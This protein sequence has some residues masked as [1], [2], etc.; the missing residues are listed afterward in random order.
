MNVFKEKKKKADNYLSKQYEN[1]LFAYEQ[2]NNIDDFEKAINFLIT[3]LEKKYS[4][5]KIS[6][7]ATY[8]ELLN[9]SVVYR[10]ITPS[11]Y[12]TAFYKVTKK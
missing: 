10:K 12:L 11:I 9:N 5:T 2:K 4:V 1:L 7:D 3:E 6:L 8:Y